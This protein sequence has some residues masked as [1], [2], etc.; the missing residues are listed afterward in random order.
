MGDEAARRAA[1][2]PSH[3]AP[4]VVLTVRSHGVHHSGPAEQDTPDE[5]AHRESDNEE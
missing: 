1:G 2:A 4:L 3:H 5:S